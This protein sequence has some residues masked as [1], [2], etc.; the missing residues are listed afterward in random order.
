MDRCCF[1]QREIADRLDPHAR[2]VAR[3][4]GE[5]NILHIDDGYAVGPRAGD[6]RGVGR[7]LLRILERVLAA[8][9][10]EHVDAVDLSLICAIAAPT[11]LAQAKCF[12]FTTSSAP[13]FGSMS[14]LPPPTTMTGSGSGES[15][16]RSTA[17]AAM[18]II[19]SRA[20]PISVCG[21]CSTFDR[22]P[23]SARPAATM[24]SLAV[25]VLPPKISASRVS[26]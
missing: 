13:I 1:L 7:L 8:R 21:K 22:S 11:A 20:L 12:G 14:T 24:M 26:R 4:V 6:D 10:A 19:R 15:R 3:N 18:S 2:R 17:L 9:F 25:I 23:N 5:R 16:D